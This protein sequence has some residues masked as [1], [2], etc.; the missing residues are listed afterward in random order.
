[1]PLP[2]CVRFIAYMIFIQ[3]TSHESGL[4][5]SV[6]HYEAHHYSPPICRSHRRTPFHYRHECLNIAQYFILYD[7]PRLVVFFSILTVLFLA[8]Y[9]TYTIPSIVNATALS[10]TPLLPLPFVKSSSGSMKYI[11]E[12]ALNLSYKIY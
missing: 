5:C 4:R 11:I 6:Y 8:I 12:L 3:P 9:N 7:L 1:M 2:L 10:I